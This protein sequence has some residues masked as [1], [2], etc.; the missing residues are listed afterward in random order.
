MGA[1]AD[2]PYRTYRE[3]L[4]HPQ[5]RAVRAIV[6]S[7]ASGQCEVCNIARASEVHHLR[8][9]PWGTID[10]PENLIAIC[11]PCHCRIHNKET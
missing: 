3:Y 1:K 5:F 4:R 9:P 2:P 8:Y 7:R 10:V 6:M 11:H